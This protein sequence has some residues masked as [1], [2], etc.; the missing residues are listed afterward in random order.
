MTKWQHFLHALGIHD[1]HKLVEYEAT[2]Y[3][4]P[5]GPHDPQPHTRKVTVIKKVCCQCGDKQTRPF[6][7]DWY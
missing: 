5:C 3:R 7:L 2:I 1:W 4:E 6:D